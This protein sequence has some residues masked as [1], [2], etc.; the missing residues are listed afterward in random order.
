MKREIKFRAW[1]SKFGIMLHDVVVYD[2]N[3]VVMVDVAL[4]G[5]YGDRADERNEAGVE[6]A[7]PEWV[8]ITGDLDVM[9]FT[10]LKDKNGKD[11]Y[12]GDIVS[13]ISYNYQ[14]LD[15]LKWI[16]EYDSESLSFVFVNGN[17]REHKVTWHSFEVIGNI[18]EN[19]ELINQHPIL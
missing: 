17:Y 3:N 10:G 2:Q 19:A 16:V 6:D 13:M 15:R 7:G 8:C 1:D 9:Q 11:I 4:N 18:Y 14:H 5:A 12:E